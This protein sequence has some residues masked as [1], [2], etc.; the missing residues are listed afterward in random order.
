MA[1]RTTHSVKILDIVDMFLYVDLVDRGRTGAFAGARY[2]GHSNWGLEPRHRKT[3][4]SC[5]AIKEGRR[6]RWKLVV[7]VLFLLDARRG[8]EHDAR[9]R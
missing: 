3:D 9:V 8:I 6:S 2:Q 4:R 7:R 1:I 5:P